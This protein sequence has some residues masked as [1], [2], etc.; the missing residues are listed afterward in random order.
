MIA[1][2][3]LL[4]K[5]MQRR[6]RKCVSR[7]SILNRCTA[8]SKIKSVVLTFELRGEKLYRAIGGRARRGSVTGCVCEDAEDSVNEKWLLRECMMKE[9]MR[10]ERNQRST[11]G[12]T[13]RNGKSETCDAKPIARTSQE[14]H[15]KQEREMKRSLSV[16]LLPIILLST[17]RAKETT[18]PVERNRQP[19][20]SLIINPTQFVSFGCCRNL[21]CE[22]SV[23]G[24][25]CLANVGPAN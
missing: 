5:S 14:H 13:T 8:S 16:Y 21:N 2:H 20:R 18:P 19:P 4:M 15:K 22:P 12:R 23:S 3:Q 25:G 9:T 17:K 6:V 11:K 24:G 10:R 1:A 7:R